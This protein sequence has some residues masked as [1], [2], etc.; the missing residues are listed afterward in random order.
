MRIRNKFHINVSLWFIRRGID[1]LNDS[2][3]SYRNNE[4]NINFNGLDEFL[5]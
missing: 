3:E 5:V 1:D 2:L 4:V